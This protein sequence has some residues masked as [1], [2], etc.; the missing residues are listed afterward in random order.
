M[1][2][3]VTLLP[4]SL[5]FAILFRAAHPAETMLPHH[6]PGHNRALP[7]ALIAGSCPNSSQARMPPPPPEAVLESRGTASRSQGYYSGGASVTASPA[8][9]SRR[10]PLNADTSGSPASVCPPS[11]PYATHSFDMVDNSNVGA[12]YAQS[13]SRKTANSQASSL[14]S[15]VSGLSRRNSFTTKTLP[16]KQASGS[17]YTGHQPH[18]HYAASFTSPSGSGTFSRV[19]ARP[20]QWSAVSDVQATSSNNWTDQFRQRFQQYQAQLLADPDISSDT[21]LGPEASPHVVEEDG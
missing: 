12:S 3:A 19:Q 10:L 18:G 1:R 16:S 7:N 20:D 11:Q 2:F 4:P 13:R 9:Y 21:P 5:P 6:T 15:S 8:A 14:L 17:P